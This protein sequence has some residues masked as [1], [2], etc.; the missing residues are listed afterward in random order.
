MVL[1]TLVLAEDLTSSHWGSL[2]GLLKGPQDVVVGF[3]QGKWAKRGQGGSHQALPQKS[4]SISFARQ[5]LQ[6]TSIVVALTV[7]KGGSSP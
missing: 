6:E 2:H 3:L 5:P 4:H 1:D 7:A